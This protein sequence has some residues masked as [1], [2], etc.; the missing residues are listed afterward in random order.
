[1]VERHLAKVNVE[2]S[3]PFAR[4]IFLYTSNEERM[5]TSTPKGTGELEEW[6]S[7]WRIGLL[8]GLLLVTAFPGIVAG[9]QTFFRSD[10][11][12]IG[13]PALDFLADAFRSAKLPLWNPY[14]N[15]GVPFL[16]QWGSMCLYPGNLFFFLLPF[17]WALGMFCLLH[18]WFGGMGMFLLARRWIGSPIAASFAAVAFSFSGVALACLVWPN[19]CVALAWMPWLVLAARRAWLEGGKW[20][21]LAA[22]AGTM[23][24]LVGVP[25]LVL[26]TWTLLGAVWLIDRPREAGIGRWLMAFPLMIVLIAALSAAQL[27]P[28]FDLLDQ[29]Q[30]DASFR[31]MRWPM[32]IW[33][34]ANL[35]VPLFHY[36]RTDQE[37][38]MQQGQYFLTSYYLGLGALAFMFL[39]AW[40]RRTRLTWVLLGATALA[41][42]LALGHKGLLYSAMV[43]VIPSGG[44]AR[45]PIK[46]V[47][48]AAFTVPLLAAVGVRHFLAEV[49]ERNERRYR[50]V[51]TVIGAVMV[52]VLVLVAVAHWLS[53][54]LDRLEDLGNHTAGSLLMFG[55]V[56]LAFLKG[57]NPEIAMRLRKIYLS[58]A[59]VFLAADLLTHLPN[60][61]PTIQAG[62]LRDEMQV[63]LDQLRPR[64]TGTLQRAMIRP[65]A[66]EVLLRSVVM[67]WELDITG[68]RLAL[69]SNLNLLEDV[70]KVNG[71]MTLRQR[72]Q[73]EIQSALYPREGDAPAAEGLKDFLAVAWETHS[74]QVVQWSSRP[75]PQAFVTAGRRVSVSADA[76]EVIGHLIS[77]NFNPREQVWIA[78]SDEQGGLAA[79]TSNVSATVTN[80]IFGLNRVQFE[81]LAE[82]PTIAV[83]AQSFNRN[84]Q[85]WVNEESVEVLRANHAFQA[86]QIPAGRSIVRFEY[87]DQPFWK[88]VRI[89]LVTL[90]LCLVWIGIAWWRERKDTL[91]QL[92]EESAGKS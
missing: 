5:T 34:W 85:A 52:E 12:V 32:P 64:F 14:S 16:A 17:S 1:M 31:D 6:F 48:L 47:L 63:P 59:L 24:M 36:G 51:T 82:A 87:V 23:Q 13:F 2:G 68:K 76:D 53:N 66:E 4:S 29:S 21:P 71:S 83:V 89:S 78:S 19:Y 22:F 70:P 7:P 8:L 18:L 69:W 57:T 79:Y 55:M 84:W 72:W 61:N 75:T 65:A 10:Y 25:E 54:P 58:L 39:A 74:E 28:F 80:M 77:T 88:G 30:R 11:G 45:Y 91:A 27:L 38:F 42:V 67:P 20:I 33:G 37:L 60:Q 92:R 62:T 43:G 50:D 15:C 90:L 73:D 40:R 44:I 46:F 35:F 41:L 26:L 86:V 56:M 49:A 9:T 3:N 81:V